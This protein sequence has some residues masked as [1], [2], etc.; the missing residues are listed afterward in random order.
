MSAALASEAVQTAFQQYS[1]TSSAVLT[2]SVLT[3]TLAVLTPPLA[4][5]FCSN[6]RSQALLPG[7]TG[8]SLS[9]VSPPPRTRHTPHGEVGARRTGS[10]L[11]PSLISQSHFT[12]QPAAL[13]TYGYAPTLPVD[14]RARTLHMY[15][16]LAFMRRS[17]MHHPRSRTGTYKQ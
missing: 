14:R 12:L 8:L 6:V 1:N 9:S 3:P 17:F 15:D 10:H 2:P 5:D 16:P 11:P 13:R 7:R 4:Q